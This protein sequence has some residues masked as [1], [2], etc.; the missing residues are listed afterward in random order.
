MSAFDIGIPCGNNSDFYVQFLLK[1]MAKTM[2]APKEDTR[3]ILGINN[4]KQFDL[5]VLDPWRDRFNI[6]HHYVDTDTPPGS[7]G[8]AM[9][10]EFLLDQMTATFGAF[11]DC[12]I[13]FLEYG[14]DTIMIRELCTGTNTEAFGLQYT[15]VRKYQGFPNLIV[16]AFRPAYVKNLKIDFRPLLDPPNSEYVVQSDLEA[17]AWNSQIGQT[18]V[19]DCGFRFPLKMIESGASGKIIPYAGTGILG[20]GQ[21][22]HYNGK[23]Y[24]THLK[25]SSVKDRNNHGA[26]A[27]MLA[28]ETFLE[29]VQGIS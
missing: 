27:W 24:L 10:L 14:W 19:L 15:N 29:N 22:H 28:V 13:G 12:D 1:N 20:I 7:V 2:M 26:N 3:I 9:V 4:Y 18:V 23:P 6:E 17:R 25:G 16:C 5:S 8:H 21:E 11:I